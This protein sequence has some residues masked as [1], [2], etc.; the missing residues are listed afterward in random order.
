[1]PIANDQVYGGDILN[2]GKDKE[3]EWKEEFDKSSTNNEGPGAEK[4]MFMM[5]WLHAYQYK[6]KDI[7]VQTKVPEWAAIK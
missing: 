2:D 5:L 4:R 7:Q 3:I 1:M 6:F